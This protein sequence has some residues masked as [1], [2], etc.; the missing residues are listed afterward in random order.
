MAAEGSRMAGTMR[1]TQLPEL[2]ALSLGAHS[3]TRKIQALPSK[4][5][6]ALVRI[7]S[8]NSQATT[9]LTQR[10]LLQ[11]L[12]PPSTCRS[13]LLSPLHHT[14]RSKGVLDSPYHCS[15]HCRYHRSCLPIFRRLSP[16]LARP[17]RPITYHDSEIRLPPDDTR[18]HVP[19]SLM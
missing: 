15:C 12:A 19:M 1:Q 8:V 2:A 18:I 3:L 5:G 17:Q 13:W 4:Y 7:S 9:R 11:F 10:Q 14:F 16:A 6:V